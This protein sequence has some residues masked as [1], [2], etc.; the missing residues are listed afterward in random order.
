MPDL[1]SWLPA[2]SLVLLL[3]ASVARGV[4]LRRQG[5]QSYGFGHNSNVQGVAERF[6]KLAVGLLAACALIAW[7]APQWE[8]SLGRPSWSY[9]ERLRWAGAAFQIIG[10]LIVL[11]GQQAMGL[12]WRVGVPQDGPGALVT[13]GLF[14]FS[15]N[16][17]FVGMFLLAVGMFSWSPTMLSAALVPL[18]AAIMAVQVRIEED[19]LTAKH[20]DVYRDYARRTPRWIWPIG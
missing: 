11:A 3:T 15:R 6:W 13:G 5:V 20:G 12:S 9:D 1:P 10:V 4:A 19:R 14:R 7:L 8:T 16:P 18:A 17:V 2:A